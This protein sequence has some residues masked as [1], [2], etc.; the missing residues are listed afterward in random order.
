MSAPTI[1]YANA[2]IPFCPLL[3]LNIQIETCSL[4]VFEKRKMASNPS[5]PTKK[6]RLRSTVLFVKKEPLVPFQQCASSPSRRTK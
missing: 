5:T 1:S 2:P 6:Y 3:I 4:R